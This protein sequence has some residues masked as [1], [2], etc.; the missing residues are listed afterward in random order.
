VSPGSHD[1]ELTNVAD[2]CTVNETNPQTVGVTAGSTTNVSFTITCTQIV[3]SVQVSATTTGTELDTQ[4]TVTLSGGQGAV[5]LPANGSTTFSNVP[6]G[7]YTVTLSDIAA[8]CT[9]DDGDN[10]E[11]V[12]VSANTQSN[13]A[14]SVTCDPTTGSI[15]VTTTTTGAGTIDPDGYSVDVDGGT[16]MAIGVNDLVTFTSVATGTRTVTL[17]GLDGTCAVTS[18]N[19]PASPSVTAGMTSNVDFTVDCP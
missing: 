12:T 14:F 18:G 11:P 19:N 15:Q 5:T 8:N 9:D 3:G 13:V 4:Y 2:N 16:P 7:G 1:V 17:S 6:T 10:Q